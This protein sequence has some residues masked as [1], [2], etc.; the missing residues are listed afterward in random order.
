MNNDD[1]VFNNIKNKINVKK[2]EHFK[3]IVLKI[4]DIVDHK[5]RKKK[6]NNEY[7]FDKML[8]FIIR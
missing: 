6:Y 4:V 8:F 3:S 1:N 7:Y 2:Q 5:I